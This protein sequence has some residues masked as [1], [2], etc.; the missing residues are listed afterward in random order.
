MF[1]KEV[2]ATALKTAFLLLLLTSSITRA[3]S[4]AI[5]QGAVFDPG[6]SV[7]PDATIV[8]TN[9]AT[10]LEHSAR[11]DEQGFYQIAALPPGDYRVKA[12]ATGFRTEVVE[13][14]TLNVSGTTVQNFQL[15]IG[16]LTEEVTVTSSSSSLEAM[17]ISVGQVVDR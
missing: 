2:S 6:K 17:T 11:T 15:S 10:H 5:L 8:A 3:Q 14:L 16:S 13:R 12:R 9:L 7:V 1:P 4:T